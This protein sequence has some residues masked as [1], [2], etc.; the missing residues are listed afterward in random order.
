M[1]SSDREHLDKAIAQVDYFLLNGLVASESDNQFTPEFINTMTRV[2]CNA[3]DELL[4]ISPDLK[5]RSSFVDWDWI[6]KMRDPVVM[7]DLLTNNQAWIRTHMKDTIPKHLAKI[8]S[9]LDEKK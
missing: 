6:E 2:L 8:Q 9:I 7:Q 1:D 4:Q 5:E 3:A